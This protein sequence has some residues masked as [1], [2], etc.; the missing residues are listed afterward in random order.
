MGIETRQ[1]L[2]FAIAGLWPEGFDGIDPAQPSP[3][4]YDELTARLLPGFE[5]PPEAEF[6]AALADYIESRNSKKAR[7]GN[8]AD[9][10][11]QWSEL[12]DYIRGPFASHFREAAALLDSGTPED[13]AAAIALIAYADAPSA[14][15]A[16][17]ERNAFFE[18]VRASMIS[19]IEDLNNP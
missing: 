5:I 10:A 13:D 12:P 19:A 14:I 1:D 17:P 4:N 8:R 7:E 15:A 9:L 11:K 3:S 2:F 18:G 16:D 6:E